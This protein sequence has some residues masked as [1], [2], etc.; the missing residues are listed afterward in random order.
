M[1]TSSTIISNNKNRSSRSANSAPSI[2]CV[3]MTIL[4]VIMLLVLVTNPL[5][6]HSNQYDL[7]HS[8]VPEQVLIT[9]SDL[10]N[11]ARM[12]SIKKYNKLAQE[13]DETAH[14]LGGI[15]DDAKAIEIPSPAASYSQVASMGLPKS[16]LDGATSRFGSFAKAKLETQKLKTPNFKAPPMNK[17]ADSLVDLSSKSPTEL[18]SSMNEVMPSVRSLKEQQGQLA[19][20][21]KE[22]I[23]N[24]EIKPQ[25]HE[26]GLPKIPADSLPSSDNLM[27][28]SE[29][30]EKL[31]AAGNL[32]ELP[33]K[34]K[35]LN[36]IQ[37]S[38]SDLLPNSNRSMGSKK[39]NTLESAS[40]PTAAEAVGSEIENRNNEPIAEINSQDQLSS[41]DPTTSNSDYEDENSDEQQEQGGG[42]GE[43]QEED[44]EEILLQPKEVNDNFRL[45]NDADQKV[46]ITNEK[47]ENQV[48]TTELPVKSNGASDNDKIPTNSNKQSQEYLPEAADFDMP[49]ADAHDPEDPDDPEYSDEHEDEQEG[50][51]PMIT[52]ETTEQ[53]EPLIGSLINSMPSQRPPSRPSRAVPYQN[54]IQSDDDGKDL[55]DQDSLNDLSEVTTS[56]SSDSFDQLEASDEKPGD[57]NGSIVSEEADCSD[58]LGSTTWQPDIDHPSTSRVTAPELVTANS[59]DLD[60]KDGTHLLDST[61][62]T[63]MDDATS[64]VMIPDPNDEISDDSDENEDY[65]QCQDKDCSDLSGSTTMQPD[66]DQPSTSPVTGLELN[67]KNG[68]DLDQKDGD[69]VGENTDCSDLLGSDADEMDENRTDNGTHQLAMKTTES[70]DLSENDQDF[71]PK[72]EPS[73]GNIDDELEWPITTSD[74]ADQLINDQNLTDDF[75]LIAAESPILNDLE[76]ENLNE[77][78]ERFVLDESI[79]AISHPGDAL[80]GTAL[81]EDFNQTQSKVNQRSPRSSDHSLVQQ[82]TDDDD[83][84]Q[85]MESPAMKEEAQDEVDRIEPMREDQESEPKPQLTIERADNQSEDQHEKSVEIESAESPQVRLKDVN[86]SINNPNKVLPETRISQ[87]TVTLSNRPNVVKSEKGTYDKVKLVFRGWKEN[88]I[89]IDSDDESDVENFPDLNLLDIGDDDEDSGIGNNQN[90]EDDVI[91]FKGLP[92]PMSE[93]DRENESDNENK[94]TAPES[95]ETQASSYGSELIGPTMKPE[96]NPG[97]IFEGVPRFR[98]RNEREERE[99]RQGQRD[100]ELGLVSTNEYWD[101]KRPAK[102]N[103][104]KASKIRKEVRERSVLDEIETAK[105]KG[106]R[107]SAM[108]VLRKKRAKLYDNDNNTKKFTK[109]RITKDHHS[110]HTG[111]HDDDDAEYTVLLGTKDKRTKHHGH[112]SSRQG[113]LWKTVR[114]G[115]RR[116]VG[117]TKKTDGDPDSPHGASRR[118]SSHDFTD[119][120]LKKVKPF[121]K[122]RL[123]RYANE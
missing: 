9:P 39:S 40:L 69:L 45:T 24:I 28:A 92:F 103:A 75:N 33:A 88:P 87:V 123:G 110:S 54:S 29:Q 51:D 97:E 115:F 107:A 118:K 91:D 27:K 59:A 58:L 13:A 102:R 3:I 14:D 84:H 90:E 21:M 64:R 31:R 119:R 74:K 80:P 22:T 81:N 30:L 23:S 34:P 117:K 108:R 41:S 109:R 96:E 106:K 85:S 86:I 105:G 101:F 114:K 47:Y 93:R 95:R 37:D 20:S 120:L 10:A 26:L 113:R 111:G 44:E 46:E 60:Q 78:E 57:E 76:V 1:E 8:F 32:V 65:S 99:K 70:V 98:Y 49:L 18:M 112:H 100:V 6:V 16:P 121:I 122:E 83:I 72:S 94:S 66:I 116:V 42:E 48:K 12:S 89:E 25:L 17:A 62:P 52:D 53:D 38:L 36:E 63:D 35:N 67:T 2:S 4:L 71:S 7:I 19:N 73:I 56:D 5:G 68:A 82:F 15:L 43:R 11:E 79:R 104:R 61:P 55:V 77:K 50:D